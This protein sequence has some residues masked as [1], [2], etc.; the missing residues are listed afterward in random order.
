MK[1]KFLRP[2]A[3]LVLICMIITSLPSCA[4][5]QSATDESGNQIDITQD[6][7]NAGGDGQNN[8]DIGGQGQGSTGTPDNGGQSNTDSDSGSG[9][10][11]TSGNGQSSGSGSTGTQGGST[12]TSP[13]TVTD[14]DNY[15]KV[16][17]E[18]KLVAPRIDIKT[19]T[20]QDITSKDISIA[21]TV[22]V[23]GDGYFLDRA[24]AQVRGRGNSTW[25]YSD[26]KPYKVTFDVKQD[27]F[28]LGAG[29]KWVLL[30]NSFDITLLRNQL[31]FYLAD[32]FGMEYT[33]KYKWV[34]VFIND[35]YKGV[36]LLTEQVQE[37]DTRVTINSSKTGEED[38][39]YLIEFDGLGDTGDF[40]YFTINDVPGVENNWLPQYK[41]IVK[42]PDDKECTFAQKEY[43][44]SYVNQVNRAILTKNWSSI[45]K[46]IDVD[47]FVNGFLVN[48]IVL[49][50]DMGWNMFLYKKK[51]GKLY[52]GPMWDFD[53]CCGNSTHGGI[54]YEG[55]YAGTENLWFTALYSMPQFRTLVKNKF[56]EML[57]V[58]EGLDTIIDETIA[59]YDRD[60]TMNYI[61]WDTIGTEIW[62]SPPE[63]VS[64]YSYEDHIDY[65]KTWLDNRIEWL[66]NNIT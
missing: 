50:N 35:Q 33:P 48:E 52:F 57:S 25:Q 45:Q 24:S 41:G 32:Q 38:T 19:S 53:Q 58:I 23:N 51:G 56:N 7:P 55:W 6:D 4:K 27:L 10:T 60:I 37:S 61:V 8:T 43:I 44:G 12:T 26:K 47:S 62:R 17:D 21:C 64:L 59:K 46:L 65:L 31:T 34:N 5:K 39:G 1:K 42:S 18:S 9:G 63:L 36:Y 11:G 22:T 13:G 28:G 3:F 54:T 29:R 40:M 2:A 20:N 16:Y 49:N 15:E 14:S 66:K 30:A